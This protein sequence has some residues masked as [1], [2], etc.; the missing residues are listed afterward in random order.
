MKLPTRDIEFSTFF[1]PRNSHD[2][3]NLKSEYNYTKVDDNGFVKE[4]IQVTDNDVLISK[5]VKMALKTWMIQ[6]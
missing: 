2:S 4:G 3:V 1:S 5:Y 6:R